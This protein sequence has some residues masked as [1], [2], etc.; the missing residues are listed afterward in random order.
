MSTPWKL[1]I[2]AAVSAIS[3]G[4]SA[5]AGYQFLALA[6]ALIALCFGVAV[7]A[8]VEHQIGRMS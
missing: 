5:D 8:A 6:L 1:A 4:V 3:A 7:A 2:C